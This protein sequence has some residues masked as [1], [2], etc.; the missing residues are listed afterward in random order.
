ME[1]IKL[2]LWTV[3][4]TALMV[5]SLF[6]FIVL[7]AFWGA[8]SGAKEWNAGLDRLDRLNKLTGKD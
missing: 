2:C 8:V 7:G 4:I 1:T 6:S 3:I 5:T